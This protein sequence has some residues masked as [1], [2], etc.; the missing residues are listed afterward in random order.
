MI[1]EKAFVETEDIGEGTKIWD[2]VK[3]SKN[4]KIGKNVIIGSLAHIDKD[5]VI[6]DNCRIEGMAF[7]APG[8]VLKDNVFVGPGVVFTNDKYPT[9]KAS[10]EGN[11]EL[12]KT[13]VEEGASIGANATI[14][15][16]LTIGKY[17]FVGAGSVV[18]KDVKPHTLVYGTPAREKGTVCKC[19]K[20]LEGSKCSV[21]GFKLE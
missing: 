2:F 21:C 15:C 16:G 5:V 12:K 9:A 6:G 18:T 20:R 19:G 13:I 14:L 17:S 1:S 7:L 11:W 10:K 4:T 3:V 8:V